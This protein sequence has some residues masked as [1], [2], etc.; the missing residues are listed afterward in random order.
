ME[1]K[2]FL[3]EIPVDIDDG[4]LVS[5]ERNTPLKMYGIGFQAAKCIPEIPAW[6]IKKYIPS[7]K[8]YK[9]LDPFA[10][11]GTTV[12]EALKNNN[13]VYWTDNNP[14]SRLICQCKS[15]SVNPDDIINL[16]DKMY[17]DFDDD[18]EVNVTMTFANI[19]LWFQKSVQEALTFIKD[20]VNAIED[21]TLRNAFLVAYSMTVR[22]MS[23]MEDSMILAAR[24]TNNREMIKYSRRDV[25]DNYKTN[26]YKVAEA[27]DEWNTIVSSPCAY[28]IGTNDARQ[29][30]EVDFYDAIVTSPPYI[31]AMDYVWAT[32]FELHWLDMVDGDKGRLAISDTEIGTERIPAKIYKEL[33]VTENDELNRI[34]ADI[35]YGKEYKATKGQNEMRSRV[36]YQYFL[37]MAEHFEQ[38]YKALKPG[39]KYCFII[40]DVSKITG[41][42]IPVA[43]ML[44]D[45][46]ESK[47]FKETF[48]FNLLLKNRRLNIPRAS[49]A[50]TIKHDT[51][52]VLE[53]RKDK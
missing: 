31:N 12:I 51:V 6:F 28:D 52:I 4:T 17:A 20:K 25:F 39:G 46:A 21:T 32:K 24:R 11:S 47:G 19:D 2:N 40:G 5:I 38:A 23:E 14:L 41:V 53:K 48:R 27:Y 22:K 49:F 3:G 50:G 34:L 43:N 30:N 7:G 44:R 18:I 42:E 1:Y 26:V 13:S 16:M 35:Y 36:V 37:D 33:A 45:I 8:Q 9:I 29:I 10:G 15:V